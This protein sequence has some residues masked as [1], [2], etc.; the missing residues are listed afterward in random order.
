MEASSQAVQ[1]RLICIDRQLYGADAPADLIVAIV[2]GNDPRFGL[3]LT[4][5]RSE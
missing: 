1:T 4:R 3:A 5:R 2:G